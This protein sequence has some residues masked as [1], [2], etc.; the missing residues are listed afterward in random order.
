MSHVKPVSLGL[1]CVS[2]GTTDSSI[3]GMSLLNSFLIV[4]RGLGVFLITLYTRKSLLNSIRNLFTSLE[5][6]QLTLIDI[7]LNP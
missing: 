5:H 2:S 4:E 7:E 3:H 6:S 1:L